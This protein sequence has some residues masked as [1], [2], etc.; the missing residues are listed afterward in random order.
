[1]YVEA[2]DVGDWAGPLSGISAGR[3]PQL[4]RSVHT[5][6]SVRSRAAD[7][8]AD[9]PTDDGPRYRMG[10]GASG[11]APFAR[12]R[13]VQARVAVHNQMGATWQ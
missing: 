8:D 12:M 13:T 5:W 2:D 3:G 6:L 9:I 4:V 11:G 10:L 7:R 1:M